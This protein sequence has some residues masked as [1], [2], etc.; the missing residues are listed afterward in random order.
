MA[1]NIHDRTMR[2]LLDIAARDELKTPA[3]LYQILRL[4]AKYRSHLIGNTLIRGG[5][6]TVRS[7]PF[8]GMTM[9]AR[10]AEG[11]HVPKLLGCYEQELHPV[12]ARCAEAGYEAVVNI[13]CAEGYYAVGLARLLGGAT[14]YAHD[15]DPAAQEACRALAEVNGVADRV[16]VGGG[17]AAEDFEAYRGR[18]AL[19]VCD[20]EGAER[21]LLDPSRAPALAGFDILVELHD[22]FDRGVSAEVVARFAGSH[23]IERFGPGARD[24]GAF[25]ELVALEQL[26]QW[27]GVWEW[28]SGPTPWAFMRARQLT[29]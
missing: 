21:D 4:V 19:V 11:C 24:I 9:A 14:V 17:F 13:G 26:D 6:L 3:K 27:L 8:A 16:V 1:T 15:L 7:G 10:S 29:A 25:P 12:L 28:R 22:L 5:G 2:L 20:I 18:R 23:D